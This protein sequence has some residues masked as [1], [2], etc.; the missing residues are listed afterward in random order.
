MPA[1]RMCCPCCRFCHCLRMY[2]GL[3]GPRIL[4][5][6]PS[7]TDSSTITIASAPGGSGAPVIILLACPAET[8]GNWLLPARLVPTISKVVPS[9][10][11]SSV[12]TA[13]P[14][15]AELSKAGSSTFEERGEARILPVSSESGVV[16]VC[17]VK[18]SV[19]AK[20][21]ARS[22]LMPTSTPFGLRLS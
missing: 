21:S 19:P 13:Q 6:F 9:I 20:A 17:R 1:G 7:S 18:F 10:V 2:P 15:I 8:S 22:R 11:Q 3:A 16:S 4:T 12:R 5:S 14:S